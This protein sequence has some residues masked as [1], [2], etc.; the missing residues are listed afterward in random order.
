MRDFIYG[1]FDF[2][3]NRFITPVVSGA[4][5]LILYAA[6]TV[7]WLGFLFGGDSYTPFIVRFLITAVGY[8]LSVIGIR[9]WLETMV[10][11]TKIANI[12]AEIKQHIKEKEEE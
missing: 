3:F 6:A 5:L 10:A 12:T 9:I 7:G 1:L 8:P 4:V 2:R 11:L